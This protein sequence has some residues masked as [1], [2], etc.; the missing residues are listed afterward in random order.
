ADCRDI[1]Q[2]QQLLSALMTG[3]TRDTVARL[4]DFRC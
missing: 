3:F 1:L 4:T 2:T